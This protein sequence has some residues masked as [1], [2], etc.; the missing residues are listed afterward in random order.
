MKLKSTSRK[1]GLTLVALILNTYGE[2]KQNGYPEDPE[3]YFIRANTETAKL[4]YDYGD[5]VINA[6]RSGS[7]KLRFMGFK[8]LVDD[9]LETMRVVFGPETVEIKWNGD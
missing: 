8:V 3:I 1:R 9:R 7:T 4:L 2:Y 5:S 6:H